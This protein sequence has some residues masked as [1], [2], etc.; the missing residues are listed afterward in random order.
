M[1]SYLLRSFLENKDVP[2]RPLPANPLVEGYAKEVHQE[3]IPYQPN[4]MSY[5][6]DYLL[7]SI[8]RG[9]IRLPE[10]QRL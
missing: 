3:K 8:D 2:A 7:K 5:D 4:P 6:L 10:F 1:N 9:T